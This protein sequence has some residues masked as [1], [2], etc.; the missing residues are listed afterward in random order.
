M[1]RNG[2]EAPSSPVLLSTFLIFLAGASAP[3]S[4]GPESLFGRAPEARA[5]HQDAVKQLRVWSQ[6]A[7]RSRD[8]LSFDEQSVVL[9]LLGQTRAVRD[10][11]PER[12]PEIDLI[13]LDLAG[14]AWIPTSRKSAAGQKASREVALHG[15]N[16]LERR[17]RKA[18]DTFGTWLGVE[19]LGLDSQPIERRIV[20]ASML[21]GKY[22]KSTRATLLRIARTAKTELRTEALA[23]LA[24]W[25]DPAV[26]QFFLDALGEDGSGIMALASHLETVGDGLGSGMLDRS[27]LR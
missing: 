27:T 17:L 25:A 23:A 4:A 26:H 13:L 8:G 11:T 1:P 12:G 24:G 2:L 15:R 19:V 16:E 10:D 5:T 6:R 18:P 20:A 21:R 14:L 3:L 22:F 9:D 7:Q